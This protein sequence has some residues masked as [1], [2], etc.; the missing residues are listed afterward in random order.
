[1]KK[2]LSVYLPKKIREQNLFNKLKTIAKKRNRSINYVVIEAL[3]K[4][5]Q[6]EPL[7]EEDN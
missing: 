2:H 5:V 7:I 4:Y 3:S 6:N 1:M